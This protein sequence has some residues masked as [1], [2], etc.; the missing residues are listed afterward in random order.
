MSAIGVGASMLIAVASQTGWRSPRVL[1]PLLIAGRRSYEI[2][3]THMFV[4][5]VLAELF[6][7]TGKLMWAVP[8]FFVGVLLV[9]GLLGDAVARFYSEP[10]NRWLRNRWKDGARSLGSVVETAATAADAVLR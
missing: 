9:G 3:L 7:T 6:V 10:M 1:A 2:Y 5:V 4:V 8:M